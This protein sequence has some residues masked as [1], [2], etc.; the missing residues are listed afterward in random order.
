MSSIIHTCIYKIY[1]HVQINKEPVISL[2]SVVTHTQYFELNISFQCYICVEGI[3]LLHVLVSTGYT[4]VCSGTRVC[5]YIVHVCL[6]SVHTHTLCTHSTDTGGTAMNC[7][8]IKTNNQICGSLI[9]SNR[10]RQQTILFMP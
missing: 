7:I 9:L 1:V 2:L 10:P 4:G 5:V 8:R 3:L 6:C